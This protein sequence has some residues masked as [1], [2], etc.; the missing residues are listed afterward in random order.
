MYMGNSPKNENSK[1]SEATWVYM[2]FLDKR[3][4]GGWEAKRRVCLGGY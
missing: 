2:T 1:N 4:N 3:E